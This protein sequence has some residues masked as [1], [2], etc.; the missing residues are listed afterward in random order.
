MAATTGTTN[1]P[2]VHTV[3][4]SF[5]STSG[6]TITAPVFI[7]SHEEILLSFTIPAAST[8]YFVNIGSILRLKLND[9]LLY[10]DQAATIKTNSTTGTDTF[11]LKAGVPYFWTVTG[12]VANPLSADITTGIYITTTTA[13]QS[14]M[15]IIIGQDPQS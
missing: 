9:L 1:A 7:T 10:S 3:T 13:V 14:N 8:N 4:L 11:S 12:G 6:K 15:D 5:V 2:Y